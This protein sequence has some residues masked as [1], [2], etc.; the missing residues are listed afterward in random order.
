M[1]NKEEE[2]LM[3]TYTF[4]NIEELRRFIEE[5]KCD[6]KAHYFWGFIENYDG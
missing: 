5:R 1:D 3:K 6:D 4:T 2:K